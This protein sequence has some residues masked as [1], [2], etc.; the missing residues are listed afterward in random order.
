MPNCEIVCHECGKVVER[1]K[2]TAKYCEACARIVRRRQIKEHNKLAVKMSNDTEKMRMMCLSCERPH[3]NGNCKQLT[4]L[5]KEEC[6]AT[7]G[8]LGGL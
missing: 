4:A 6:N 8:C 7:R 5:V 3:C 2:K 1:G